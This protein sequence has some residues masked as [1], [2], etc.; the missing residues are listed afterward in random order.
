MLINDSIHISIL[1]NFIFSYAVRLKTIRTIALE[2]AGLP[3]TFLFSGTYSLMW[4]YNLYL[5]A[6]CPDIATLKIRKLLYS[7]FR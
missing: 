4:N 2:H 3:R 1:I 7:E 6:I 5:G